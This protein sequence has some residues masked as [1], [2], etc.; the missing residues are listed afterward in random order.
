MLLEVQNLTV[1]YSS[2]G[3][4]N[5]AVTDVSFS[6][7]AG[8]VIGVVGESGCGKSTAVLACLGLA[9]H[10]GSIEGGSVKMDGHQLL[11]MNEDEWRG[12]RGARIA[13]VTQN[14]RASLN[15]MLRVGDQIEAFYRAHNRVTKEQARERAQALLALVGINDPMR[16]MAAFPHELSGGMAQR[17]VIAIAL[18]CEPQ[19]LIADEPTSGLDVTVQ[20]QILDDLRRAADEVGSSVVLVT[21]DLGMVANYC[22]RIY[23]LHAGEVVEECATERFFDSPRHPASMALLTADTRTDDT[24][25]RLKG[26]P[27]DGRNLPDGCYLH[28]RCPLADSS[29]GCMA[30]HPQL[31]D[32]EAG[33]RVRCHRQKLVAEYTERQHDGEI[34]RTA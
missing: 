26:L 23:L 19:L 29:A 17:V 8:E 14:P 31:M 3:V 11:D 25:W 7:D 18:S 12:W 16:R 30:E 5:L 4:R 10:G 24:M 13:L 32:A 34:Q 22:D 27:V 9:R 28:P 2:A 15:P 21:Q 20:A 1:S 33:H 6:V